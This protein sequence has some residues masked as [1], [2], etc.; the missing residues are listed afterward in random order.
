[1]AE[2]RPPQTTTFESSTAQRG[3]R[4]GLLS[5]LVFLAA[6]GLG[7]LAL[8]QTQVGAGAIAGLW[9]RARPELLLLALLSM[10]MAFFFMG[11]R[12][13]ALMPP[14]DRKSVV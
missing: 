7:L 11:L 2:P 13:R 8:S 6:I 9:A 4:R 5:V 12:W 10:T 1:M 3:L 14:G